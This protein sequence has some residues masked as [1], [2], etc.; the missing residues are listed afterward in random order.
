MVAQLRH[1]V[2]RI[3]VSLQLGRSGLIV[4]ALTILKHRAFT[5]QQTSLLRRR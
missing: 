1:K 2:F 3:L 5:N 4:E